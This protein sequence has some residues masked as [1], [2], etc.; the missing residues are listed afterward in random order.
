MEM[1]QIEHLFDILCTVL[2]FIAKPLFWTET[3]FFR[4]LG[5]PTS[6]SFRMFP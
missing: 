6:T 3:L 5:L 4:M 2:S 1:D